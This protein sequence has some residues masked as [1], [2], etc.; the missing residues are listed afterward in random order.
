MASTILSDFSDHYPVMSFFN[1]N[2]LD[3]IKHTKNMHPVYKL[4]IS[5]INVMKFK[6]SLSNIA[7][8]FISANSNNNTDYNQFL[9]IV[10]V[11]A[12]KCFPKI[13]VKGK[14][15]CFKKTIN[16]YTGLL[17]SCNSRNEIYTLAIKGL[18]RFSV[19]WQH[20]NKL[21]NLIKAAKTK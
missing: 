12:F 14:K 20:R 16:D 19:Y 11:N 18:I 7:R 5:N 1:L 8:A 10:S 15:W 13:V 9:N 17:K 21:T 3:G 4:D 2:T 6:S